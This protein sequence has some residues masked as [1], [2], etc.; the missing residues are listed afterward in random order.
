MHKDYLVD[1]GVGGWTNNAC[2]NCPSVAGQ[3]IVTYDSPCQY[4]YNFPYPISPCTIGIEAY[5]SSWTWQLLV[6][7]GT[8][9]G[10]G[11]DPYPA[12]AIYASSSFEPCAD[13]MINAQVTLTK[14]Y[15]NTSDKCTG[16]LPATVT[17]EPA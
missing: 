17:I 9:N 10:A 13:A 2:D 4:F 16:S 5:I 6:R 12:N 11:F 3:F 8:G 1:L 15:E 7:L 14:T